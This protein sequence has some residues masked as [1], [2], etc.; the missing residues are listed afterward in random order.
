MLKFLVITFFVLFVFVFIYFGYYQDYKRNPK[1]FTRS[2]IGMPIGMILETF[3][4]KTLSE[5]LKKWTNEGY[6]DSKK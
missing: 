5:K 3:G 1:D 6:K 2:I 4:F